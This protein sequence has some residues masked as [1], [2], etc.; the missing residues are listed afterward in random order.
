MRKRGKGGGG[1]AKNVEHGK[2]KK[3]TEKTERQ[4]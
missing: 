2:G 3:E 1:G 4:T